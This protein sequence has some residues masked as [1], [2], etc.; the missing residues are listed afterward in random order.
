KWPHTDVAG[1]LR[2]VR[3]L[4]HIAL[5]FPTTRYG[6]SQEA[7]MRDLTCIVLIMCGIGISS[8]A[9]AQSDGVPERCKA[10]ASVPS[11]ATTGRPALGAKISLANCSAALRFAALKLAPDDA[12][13]KA[14]ANAAKPSLDLFDEVIAANDPVMTPIAKAARADLL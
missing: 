11:S 4:P 12:S 3:T 9:R 10:A 6:D 7:V 5:V 8:V 2:A 14:L 13:I 1:T